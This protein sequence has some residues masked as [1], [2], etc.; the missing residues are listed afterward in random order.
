[1]Y[2]LFFFFFISCL[3]ISVTSCDKFETN[4]YAIKF[5]SEEKDLTSKQLSRLTAETA[6][7]PTK[8]IVTIAFI[9][10]SQRALDEFEDGINHINQN[11]S[12]D[13]V[14]HGGDITDYGLRI[15]YE[16]M[17][18]ALRK[19]KKPFFAAF[20]NHDALGTGLS[21]YNVMFGSTNF[22]FK[23]WGIKYIFFNGNHLEFDFLDGEAPDFDF[24]ESELA[25]TS[26]EFD[27]IV[28]VAHMGPFHGEFGD[29]N[30][31]RYHN[32]IKDNGKVIYSM[33][34]HGH[35]L[36]EGELYGS[37]MNYLQVNNVEDKTYQL[38]HIYKDGKIE[39]EEVSF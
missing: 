18:K 30:S 20:G 5:D 8:D 23:A 37:G 32:L 24:L 39:T 36:M 12:V 4:P 38:V 21:G 35:K 11:D 34:G 19:L 2:R 7:N 14:F 16:K 26:S 29:D 9:S 27:K 17:G 25:E 3:L 13:L 10:D 15:E 33:H 1:M 6:Q 28:M 31:E 22:S